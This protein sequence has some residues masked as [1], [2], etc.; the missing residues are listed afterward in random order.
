MHASALRRTHQEGLSYSR[1]R[2]IP[3]PTQDRFRFLFSQRHQ[4]VRLWV[5]T[6]IQRRSIGLESSKI[7][8]HQTTRCG[9]VLEGLVFKARKCVNIKRHAVGRLLKAWFQRLSSDTSS[10]SVFVETSSSFE[11][12][13]RGFHATY[14]PNNSKYGRHVL[15][16]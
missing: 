11:P 2:A 6:R 1:S 14:I 15:N 16:L 12:R 9:K 10:R 8:Q 5:Q 3:L 13:C 4:C 7:R